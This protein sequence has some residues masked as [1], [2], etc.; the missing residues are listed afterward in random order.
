MH[1]KSSRPEDPTRRADPSFDYSNN[2]MAITISYFDCMNVRLKRGVL[3]TINEVLPRS[4]NAVPGAIELCMAEGPEIV[5]RP[6][7]S[8]PRFFYVLSC[9]YL[10]PHACLKG[11]RVNF[12]AV[13]FCRLYSFAIRVALRMLFKNSI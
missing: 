8:I 4:G 9:R 7:P 5:D 3:H 11:A 13:P 6:I 10:Q 2:S 1:Q 12:S